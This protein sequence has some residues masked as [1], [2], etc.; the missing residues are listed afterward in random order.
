MTHPDLLPLLESH[1]ISFADF[2]KKGRLPKG[3]SN[4]IMSARKGVVTQLHERGTSWADMIAIT[5]LS[6]GAIQRLTDA[7]WNPASRSTLTRVGKNVGTSWKG[8]KRPGQL[9]KQWESGVFDFFKG[10]KLTGA[11]KQHLRESWTEDHR[12]RAGVHSKNLWSDTAVRDRLLSFHRSPEQRQKRSESQTLRMKANPE[13]YAR[14]KS[15]WVDTPK[16]TTGRVFVRSSYEVKAVAKLEADTTV[17]LYEYERRIRLP[18]GKWMLPDFIALREGG[19]VTLVEVK[20]AWVFGLPEDSKE[21]NRLR[22][23]RDYSA[24]QGWSFEVWTEKDLEC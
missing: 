22:V 16:G 24:S 1:G 14:G 20:S 19:I 3:E 15:Q 9:K 8:K 10:R 2:S 17:L 7:M 11:Q 23:A 6:Q 5:G 4:R 13:K 21:Q 12:Q 18:N